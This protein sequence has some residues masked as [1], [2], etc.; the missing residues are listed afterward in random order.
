MTEL[1]WTAEPPT[2][3]GWYWHRLNPRQYH[4]MVEVWEVNPGM[5]AFV[6]SDPG[7]H[8]ITDVAKMNAEWAG[9]IPEPKEAEA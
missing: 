7:G 2:K 4:E 8:I 3:V 1:R 9:P 6:I 5:G